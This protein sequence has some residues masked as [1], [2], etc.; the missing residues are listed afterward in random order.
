MQLRKVCNHPFVFGEV[1]DSVNP[2]GTI[3]DTIWRTSGKFELLDR[4]FPKLFATDHRV[5]MFFQMTNVMDIMEDYL[6]YKE[7]VFMRL[8]GSTK[9]DERQAMLK[10]FN[11]PNS[12]YKIFL[13]STRAGG[14]GL[15]LQTADTVIIFDSDWNPHQD[16]QAQDRAHRIGQT[17]EVRILRLITADSVEEKILQRAQYKL[18]MDGKVIQAGKFDQKT[19]AEEREAILR[20]LFEAEEKEARAAANKEAGIANSGDEDDE[21]PILNDDEL[22]EVLAR[23]DE[24]LKIFKKMD[25]QRRKEEI[26]EHGAKWTRLYSDPEVPA[27]YK[28][29][30]EDI[31]RRDEEENDVSGARRSRKSVYYGDV[32]DD[33]RWAEL[34]E[35]GLTPEEI[36]ER[37]LKNIQKREQTKLRRLAG[38]AG[39]G[40]GDGDEEEGKESGSADASVE[41]GDGERSM[42][43]RRGQGGV[44][45]NGDVAAMAVDNA[46][47]QQ[48]HQNQQNQNQQ[49]QEQQ[50]QQQQDATAGVEEDKRKSRK[51]KKAAVP[52]G[53]AAG[54]TAT[55][56]AKPR[57]W[58][59][60][61]VDT[62]EKDTLAGNVRRSL[63]LVM[64]AVYKAVLE[65]SNAQSEFCTEVFMLL[66]DRKTYPDYYELIK[67][68]VCFEMIDTRMASNAFYKDLGQFRQD[69]AT[70]FAN[71][72]YYNEDG[73]EI[74]NMADALEKAFVAK[75]EE[76]APNGEL[77]IVEEEVG[78]A[79]G[80][81]RGKKRKAEE[82]ALAAA[83]GNHGEGEGESQGDNADSASHSGQSQLRIR[84]NIGGEKKRKV[85][86]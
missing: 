38:D 7:F 18:D 47:G 59:L 78:V 82:D 12:P 67:T 40:D 10:D 77:K 5:L 6:R 55:P 1:E 62:R 34:I 36:R 26:K 72:K 61:G 53:A 74:W 64:D 65:A 13:L 80:N 35:K 37:R 4:I 50:Q 51:S 45:E 48:N 83:N 2:L 44:P 52:A 81:K 73:S 41:G 27:H 70:L 57:K 28:H 17:K 43:K 46:D 16:L 20:A 19:S 66:P 24:E 30:L 63:N 75:M 58:K 86:E 21:D 42:R 79:E 3:N 32:A 84:I 54:G 33:D 31:Y 85:D 14:L 9:A 71:A 22:N 69:F 11:A 49:G 68:P 60:Y 23:S 76:M 29:D 15:N 39:D 56:A 25:E 8:D